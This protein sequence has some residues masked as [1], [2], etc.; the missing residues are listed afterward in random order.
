[1][2]LGEEAFLTDLSVRAPPGRETPGPLADV[3]ESRS[4]HTG[5]L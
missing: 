1:M 4:I 3:W 5:R 2:R